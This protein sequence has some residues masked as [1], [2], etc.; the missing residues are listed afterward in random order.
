MCI[1][2]TKVQCFLC[3]ESLWL[4]V[5]TKRMYPSRSFCF[6]VFATKIVVWK[7]S[8]QSTNIQCNNTLLGKAY[9]ANNDPTRGYL[10]CTFVGRILHANFWMHLACKFLGASWVHVVPSHRLRKFFIPNFVRHQFWPRLLQEL[11]YLLGLTL[12]RLTTC[13]AY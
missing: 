6:G 8:L 11:G 13:D 10:E 3:N 7:C 5:H 9:G 4:V 2:Y 1:V 12:I